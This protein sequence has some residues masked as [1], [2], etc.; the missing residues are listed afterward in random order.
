[1]KSCFRHT[2]RYIHCFETSNTRPG[3]PNKLQKQKRKIAQIMGNQI[4]VIHASFNNCIVQTF[5]PE[6]CC[7]ITISKKNILLFRSQFVSHNV[8]KLEC[9]ETTYLNNIL[10]QYIH[11][12]F[13]L[14]FFVFFYGFGFTI[15]KN[16]VNAISGN[17]AE[18]FRNVKKCN[19]GKMRISGLKV[20]T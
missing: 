12:V 14:V 2:H 3:S 9:V 8:A 6:V 10:I 11:I 13:F 20:Y 19:G 7:E 1:M 4:F 5:V 17:T 15:K 18:C 16:H